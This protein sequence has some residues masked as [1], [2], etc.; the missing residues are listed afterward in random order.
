[1][2]V[3]ITDL[4][5]EWSDAGPACVAVGHV[6]GR[7]CGERIPAIVG[8]PPTTTEDDLKALGA[9]SA[10]A[11]AV[12]MFHAVGLTPEAATLDDALQ[13]EP[14]EEVIR[15]SAD[16]LR[17]TVRD[18]STVPDGTALSAVSLGTR[19][20]RSPSSPGWCRCSTARAR[21]STCTSTPAAK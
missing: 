18:L 12:A 7:R 3:D 10:S 15:L 1:M 11:G 2:V 9:V 6:I 21:R 5:P 17:A 16:D 8:L 19:I 4:P 13:G 20:S 14:P